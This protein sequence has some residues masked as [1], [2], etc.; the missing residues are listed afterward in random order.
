MKIVK[1]I[2]LVLICLIVLI[3]LALFIYL[4]TTKP[5]YE[6]EEALKNISKQ[7][8]VYYDEYGVPHIYADNQKD[9]ERHTHHNKQLFAC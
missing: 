2:V 4:Q 9:A 3:A 5:K 8:T 6:G 7:T 1:K